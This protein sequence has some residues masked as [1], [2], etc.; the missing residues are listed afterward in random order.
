M[1]LLQQPGPIWRGKI[2]PSRFHPKH[3]TR[4]Y[5]RI[6]HAH[7]LVTGLCWALRRWV[8]IRPWIEMRWPD[9]ADPILFDG[10]LICGERHYRM[11]RGAMPQRLT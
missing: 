8:R 7:P 11:L 1:K 9:D 3:P 2:V 6:Y 10:M 4:T 5:R